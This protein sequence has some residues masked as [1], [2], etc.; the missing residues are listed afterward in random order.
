MERVGRRYEEWVGGKDGADFVEFLDGQRV[1]RVVRCVG[2]VVVV[3][4]GVSGLSEEF[5]LF[6]LEAVLGGAPW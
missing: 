6:G 4:R 1:Q 2:R 5:G 3:A